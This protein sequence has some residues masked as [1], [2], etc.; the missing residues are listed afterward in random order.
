M[1][2]IFLIYGDEAASAGMTQEEQMQELN[3]YNAFTA[4]AMSRGTIASAEALLPTHTATTVRV[5]DEKTLTTD[6]PF[7]ETR[8]AL[9]GYYV[10]DCK[11]LDEAIEIAAKI[12]GALNGSVEIRPVMVFE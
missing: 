10:I 12:P 2:Y 1:K 11:D 8:E 4:F 9:G 6:G 3:D 7:A 5:R